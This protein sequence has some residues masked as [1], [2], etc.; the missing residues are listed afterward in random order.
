MSTSTERQHCRDLVKKESQKKTLALDME[1]VWMFYN[2]SIIS[3]KTRQLA[4]FSHG[5]G[6]CCVRAIGSPGPCWVWIEYKITVRSPGLRR[7]KGCQ[8][9]SSVWVTQYSEVNITKNQSAVQSP[10][11]SS[12]K[13]PFCPPGNG[14]RFSAAILD[15]MTHWPPGCLR[16]RYHVLPGP[17][18]PF[19]EYLGSEDSHVYL[20]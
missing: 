6:P 4:Q 14:T 17:Y 7:R 20:E 13:T 12:F 19:V 2:I 5:P 10:P 11:Y 15:R 16:S 3:R 8:R 18:K 1:T 9:L